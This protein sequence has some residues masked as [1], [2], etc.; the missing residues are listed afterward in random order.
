MLPFSIF[1][2]LLFS[3]T[4][5]APLPTVLV[6][7]FKFSTLQAF[8][9]SS[10]PTPIPDPAPQSAPEDT[11]LFSLAIPSVT[12]NALPT[13]WGPTSVRLASNTVP[14]SFVHTDDRTSSTAVLLVV[15][16]AMFNCLV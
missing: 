12:L 8:E 7:S 5:L 11:A 1:L 14:H 4:L 2:F 10:L 9:W 6:D 3:A 13:Q 15:S 16:L